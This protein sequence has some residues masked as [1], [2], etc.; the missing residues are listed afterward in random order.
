MNPITSPSRSF[1]RWISVF[2][3]GLTVI[4]LIS[5]NVAMSE[6]NKGGEVPYKVEGTKVTEKTTTKKG[7]N[8]TELT[9]EFT[10]VPNEGVNADNR[11]Y[12]VVIRE[13]DY[14]LKRFKLDRKKVIRDV[15]SVAFAMDSSGSIAGDRMK[16]AK[17]AAKYYFEK[18]PKRVEAGFI[19]F[20]DEV[21]KKLG[22]S[23]NR[24]PVFTAIDNAQAKG[25]TAY[26]DASQKALDML[27]EVQHDKKAIVVMT[28]G[29]DLKSKVTKHQIIDWANSRNVK[30]YTVG[31]GKAHKLQKV[32]SI[33]VLDQSG[34]MSNPAEVGDKE[35]KMQA[36]KIAA[37]E[38]VKSIRETKDEMVRS[39]V[40]K[41]S[42]RVESPINFT[43]RRSILN[44]VIDNLV[45]EGETALYDAT[46]AGIEALAAENPKGTRAVIVLTDGI[47]TS[48]RRRVEDDI[49]PLAKEENVKLFT[50]GFGPKG[51]LAEGVLKKMADE[52]GGE[53]FH[54]NNKDDLIQI[55]EK[56]SLKLHDSGIDEVTLRE[57]AEKTGG[58]YHRVEN[59]KNLK[60]VLKDVTIDMSPKPFR[61]TVESKFQAGVGLARNVTIAIVPLGEEV[62]D[63]DVV[64]KKGYFREGLMIAQADPLVYLGLLIVL[65]VLLGLPAGMSYFKKAKTSA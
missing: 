55:F 9:V 11:Q 61:V 65:G 43:N 6:G 50:L 48:S 25:G 54:A 2:V 46:Y 53:Y 5:V 58:E 23:K 28:D 62:T 31:I 36:L 39:S 52:T 12:E 37:K 40:L 27:L 41:F 64:V 63:D 30:I 59:I 16:D 13:E 15:F 32:T 56:L 29:V 38:F 34:S 14:D 24:T 8:V 26:L 17:E 1:V 44:S 35:S 57:M 10:V 42:D 4:F 3:S 47:D 18:L 60:T 33:M 7:R 22:R 20:N 19:M 51:Q 49:I 21:Y 45:P